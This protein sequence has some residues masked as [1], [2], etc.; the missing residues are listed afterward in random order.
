MKVLFINVSSEEVWEEK[1]ENEGILDLG[2]NLHHN[3]KTYNYDPYDERNLVVIGSSIINYPGGFRATIIFRSPLHGGLHASTLGGFG[4][5][6]RRTGYNTIVIKGKANKPK[7]IVIKDREVE[8]LEEE[9][10][11]NIHKKEQELREQFK[12]YYGNIPYRILLTGIASL[13]TSFGA[14]FSKI[15]VAGRGG[16]GS[17]LLRA[18][19]VVGLIVGGSQKI[20]F[21]LPKID[22]VEA[23]KKYRERGTFYGNYSHYGS[24]LPMYNWLNI[25][26]KVDLSDRIE[27]LIS[28]YCPENKTCGE[29]CPATCKKIE[30]NVK[31]DYE[32]AN[33]LGPFIGIFDRE[34]IGR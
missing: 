23:T 33:A 6:I 3:D 9:V 24:K 22:I 12:E 17:V 26:K 13:N 18:H 2:T 20:S 4:E 19:N 16:G 30:K 7:L 34:K 31:I 8:F 27:K 15:D 28:N 25:L 21:E 14:L 32:P 1:H 29:K 11:Q 5:F 10:P